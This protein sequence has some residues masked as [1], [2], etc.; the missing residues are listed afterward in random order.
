MQ[1]KANRV[2][3]SAGVFLLTL[4]LVCLCA[5]CAKPEAAKEPVTL[6]LSNTGLSDITELLTKTNLDKLDLRGNPISEAQY[7]QLQAALPNCEILWSV[8]VGE[9]RVENDVASAVLSVTP[10]ELEA[11]LPYLPKLM[12]VKFANASA[13]NYADLVDFASRYSALTVRWDVKI[14]DNSYPADVKSLQLKGGTV[15]ADALESAI[16]GLPALRE[17][18]L[19]DEVIFSF[20][21]QVGLMQRHP[22]LV[23]VWNVRLTDEFSVPSD[24][25][26]IDM[27]SFT[28]TDAATFSDALQLLPKLTYADLC[29][30]GLSD[31]QMVALRERYPAVKFVW[32]IRVSGWELRTDIK[33]FSTGQRNSFPNGA[34]RFVGKKHS[35]KSFRSKDFENLKY[36]SDLIALDVGHC[37]KIGDVGFIAELPKLKYLIISLCDLTDISPLAGQTELEF[38]EIKYNYITDLSPIANCT[39]LR[40][41]NCANNEISDFSVIGNMPS[42]ER[43]WMSMN[44]FTM[45]Q[46]DELRA[47]YPNVLIKASLKDPEYAESLWRKGNEGYLAMQALFGLRAQNQG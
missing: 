40:Y 47:Q 7:R 24:A 43:F 28:I 38:L 9:Q 2:F 13:K 5:S 44:N 45:S 11:A 30:C 32:L 22:D 34:G 15:T 3:A 17:V 42:L 8:P 25:T 21:E 12:D 4:A 16:A 20:A 33:G 23:F 39:K 46:V 6:N 27:R 29:G 31:E 35:Y 18:R 19:P 41:L 10:A 37:T 36:C 14:G 26:E 1:T